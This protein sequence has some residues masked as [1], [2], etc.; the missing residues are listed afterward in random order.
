MDKLN[1]I[2]SVN[3]SAFGKW[4]IY[5]YRAWFGKEPKCIL[6][7]FDDFWLA[8][9]PFNLE[10]YRQ[11]NNDIWHYWCY[12]S[13]STNELGLVACRIFGVC[14]NA[15]SIERL[16]SC[17]EFLQT[18]RR[19]RLM[20]SKAL[21]MSKLR[22]DITYGHRLHNN[23]IFIEPILDINNTNETDTNQNP[24]NSNGSENAR[25]DNQTA[26]N[27]FGQYLQGWAEMLE[28]KKN[29]ELDEEKSDMPLDDV[30]HPANDTN[31]KWDLWHHL[32]LARNERNFLLARLDVVDRKINRIQLSF[33]TLPFV[34]VFSD[35]E[36]SPLSD[37]AFSDSGT[38]SSISES[39]FEKRKLRP[40]IPPSSSSKK[41]KY[42]VNTPPRKRRKKNH[43]TSR[44]PRPI[45][46]PPS[47]SSFSDSISFSPPDSPL[48]LLPT[49]TVPPLSIEQEL[50]LSPHKSPLRPLQHQQL[51]QQQ[52]HQSSPPLSF[53][54][55]TPS[56]VSSPDHS[57]PQLVCNKMCPTLSSIKL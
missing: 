42:V 56:L 23:P 50:L 34:E 1:T 17:M 55:S 33:K 25:N 31:A 28:E 40:R 36:D 22:A 24:N 9:F 21:Q 12:V 43:T 47:N 3:Y 19:N 16:W 49:I 6:R 29:A 7:E 26:K 37:V 57:S 5:Y 54:P 14:V 27:E 2:P 20:S 18:N 15:A 13:V 38:T 30:T 45:P 10:S 41:S 4:L 51:Q 52:T 35:F 32:V 39:C 46:I 11:F 48:S 44:V 8:K 53:K